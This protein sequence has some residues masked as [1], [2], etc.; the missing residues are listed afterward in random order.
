MNFKRILAILLASLICLAA[1]T[2]CTPSS[3]ESGTSS[4]STSESGSDEGVES[5][6]GSADKDEVERFDYFNTDLTKYITVN[7]SDYKN[8]SA[9]LGKEFEDSEEG[10]K[11]Y[12]DILCAE[13]PVES[14]N[15]IVDRAIKE[16]DT[17]MLYYEG[18]KDGEKFAG[19]SNMDDEKP[20]ALVIGS[21]SFIPGFE[22]ALIGIVPSETSRE[23]LVDLNLKF[24]DD[25]KN[26]PDLAGKEVVFKV[27]VEYIVEYVPSEY[28]E[29]FI[30]ETIKYTTKDTDVK[31]SF[32]KYLKEEIIP[33]VRR[34]EILNK[35]W[36]G[37]FDK[38]V[39]KE[40]PQSEIDYYYDSYV[41]QYKYYKQYYEYFG[42]EFESLDDFV[43]QYLGLEKGADWK[44]A[45]REQCEIDVMQNL[46]FHAIAQ[47]EGIT[48][49][50]T[51]YQNSL[52]YY[53]EYYAQNG[54]NYSA[55]EIEANVGSRLIKEH[56]LFEKVQNLLVESC[57]VTYENTAEN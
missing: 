3:E 27:Y 40:Y 45:T 25:Y 22:D 39:V 8:T 49:T 47:Q 7:A 33:S 38:A 37:L 50:Q 41:D 14:D 48:I 31:A 54:Y 36:D 5:E 29:K 6:S 1:F 16:G 24:P 9:T 26:S 53:V 43:E 56:A 52:N 57:S 12:I 42:M 23:K 28:N 15:K 2:A 34:S 18:Y 21:G 20:Y 11:A 13:Y 10:L 44:A 55:A 17:V 32:E 4:E 46:V 19:G 51:D 30:T 35:V